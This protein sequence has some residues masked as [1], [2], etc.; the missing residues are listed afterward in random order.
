LHPN[1][2]AAR[3]KVKSSFGPI[4]CGP[5]GLRIVDVFIKFLCVLCLL[6]YHQI[7]N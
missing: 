2:G 1:L 5:S 6:L 3:Q 4:Q 7:L